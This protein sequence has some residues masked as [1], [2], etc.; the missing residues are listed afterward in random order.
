M[1]GG[2]GRD[3]PAAACL[4]AVHR[5]AGHRGGLPALNEQLLAQGFELNGE[6][7]LIMVGG[8]PPPPPCSCSCSVS[9]HATAPASPIVRPLLPSPTL[10]P[11]TLA[12]APRCPPTLSTQVSPDGGLLQSSTVADRVNVCFACGES[13]LVP[14]AYI[15][16]AERLPLPQFAHLPVRAGTLCALA[17]AAELLCLSWSN[18]AHPVCV[19]G[20][21]VERAPPSRRFRGQLSRP[22]LRV[23]DAGG[24]GGEA[25]AAGAAAAAAGCTV[26][27]V[28]LAWLQSC[29]Q[30]QH[31]VTVHTWTEFSLMVH[32]CLGSLISFKT[33]LR[34][35]DKKGIQDIS[36]YWRAT[37]AVTCLQAGRPRGRKTPQRR[38]PQPSPTHAGRLRQGAG[39]QQPSALT[40]QPRLT[41]VVPTFT[42]VGVAEAKADAASAVREKQ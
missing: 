28:C 34:S 7:G 24:G 40:R 6:G 4:P 17:A 31:G 16:F 26:T 20:G 30:L 42:G 32:Q 11:Q 5:L 18:A 21:G 36:L 37:L 38:L 14:G 2:R 13:A 23:D 35:N 8:C 3:Q 12:H 19:A 29:M 39:A 33:V 41:C 9:L 27:V 25:A 1:K 10:L 22:N 15:E